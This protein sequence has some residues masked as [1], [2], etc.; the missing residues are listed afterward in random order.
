MR[1]LRLRSGILRH[2]EGGWRREKIY[3]DGYASSAMGRQ[4]ALVVMEMKNITCGSVG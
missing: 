1:A 3:Q 4:M 2:L